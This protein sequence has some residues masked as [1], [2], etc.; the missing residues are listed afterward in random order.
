MRSSIAIV[1]RL[2]QVIEGD[3]TC[4]DGADSTTADCF[5]LRARSACRQEGRSRTPSSSETALCIGWSSRFLPASNTRV[6][7]SG[8]CGTRALLDVKTPLKKPESHIVEGRS[9]DV[10]RGSPQ[11]RTPSYAEVKSRHVGADRIPI[12]LN[13]PCK[14]SLGT[15]RFPHRRTDST[16]DAPSS[17]TAYRNGESMC[18]LGA[19][20]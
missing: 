17:A 4:D 10:G 7:P 14:C 8:L 9:R 18:L 2:R 5:G 11:K 13:P 15:R 20:T 12:S 6:G 1:V 16:Y 3:S 19:A